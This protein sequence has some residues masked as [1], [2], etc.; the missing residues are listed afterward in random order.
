M[1]DSPDLSSS[2]SQSRQDK[3]WTETAQGTRRSESAKAD[4]SGNVQVQSH[5]CSE[6]DAYHF[7]KLGEGREV[8][9][10]QAGKEADFL[11][12]RDLLKPA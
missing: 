4:D 3:L 7:S 1:L 5:I 12:K 6:V 8:R 2:L 11:G 10:I 9:A